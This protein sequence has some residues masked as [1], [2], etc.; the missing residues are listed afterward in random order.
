MKIKL[1]IILILIGLSTS[2][3]QI[4]NFETLS[5]T[6]TTSA[7]FLKIGVDARTTAMGNAGAA[8]QG[9]L[10][11]MYWNPAGL[12]YITGLEAMFVYQ[13]WLADVAYNYIAFA[14]G[15]GNVGTIGVSVTSLSVPED[16]VTT[17]EQPDGTGELFD[18][19]DLAINLSFSR[20]LTDKFSIGGSVKFIH[21]SIWHMSANTIAADIGALF[22]TPFKGIR[23]GA[24]ISN[25]GGDMQLSGRDTRFSK[26]PDAFNE[27][28]V[29]FVNAMYETDQFPLP[30][31]FRVGIAGE[32][33]EDENLRATFGLDALHPNDNTESLN[34]GLEV[35]FNEMLFLR[36]GYATLFRQDTEQGLTFGGGIHYRVWRSSTVLKI[37]YSYTDFGRL[38]NV[39]R[40]S[41]GVKF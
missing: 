16:R 7:Q 11:A 23:I 1:F 26:D 35:A 39:Q 24:C 38:E 4:D 17:V 19:S 18:A 29:K 25:F 21:Q 13:D 34:S 30:I 15:L 31:F 36:S 12:G 14:T 2:Y 22:T 32:L 6:G 8:M 10:S 5:K 28:N 20:R 41:L 40:F 3:G 27:G 37:D 33:Y 9:D